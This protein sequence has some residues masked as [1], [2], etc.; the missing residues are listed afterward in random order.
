MRLVL[1]ALLVLLIGIPIGC[2]H[3]ERR[4]ALVIGNAAYPKPVQLTNPA[5]DADDVTA[6]LREVGF[7]VVEG[8][9]LTLDGFSQIVETF[10]QRAKGADVALLFYAGHGMEFEDQN[11]LMPIDTKL[12]SAF[13]ARHSNISLQE[14][15]A[16]IEP[17]V[18][19]TIVFLDA[20]RTNPLADDL[21]HR[22][23]QQMQSQKRDFSETRGLGRIDIKAPQTMVVFAARPNTT[24]EDG[25]GRN[26]PFT[27]AL[28]QHV[29][30]PGVEVEA[31]MKRVSAA[32]FASTDGRQQPERLSRLE[33]E[34]YFVAAPSPA[35][36]VPA[37]SRPTLSIAS[38]TVVPDA[39]TVAAPPKPP[40]AASAPPNAPAAESSLWTM[41]W[42]S[43]AAKPAPT[44]NKPDD[45][46]MTAA[47]EKYRGW[48][49]TYQIGHPSGVS[50]VVISPDGRLVVSSGVSGINVWDA[51]SGRLLRTFA[52]RVAA[53]AVSRDGRRIVSGSWD[54]TVKIWDA[55]SGRLL[56]T[57]ASHANAV[58]AV[59]IS[60]DGHRIV[61]G[62]N[63]TI[64]EWD[65]ESGEILR[66]LPDHAN[67]EDALNGAIRRTRVVRAIA[68]SPDGRR[69][70]SG[71]DDKTIKVWDAESGAVLRTLTGHADWVYAIAVSPD[72]RRIV[73]G[74]ADKTIKIW[75]AESGRLLLTLKGHEGGVYAVTVSS[76]GKRIVSGGNDNAIRV[77][78]AE[79]GRLLQTFTGHGDYVSAVVMSPDGRR[80]V[81][82]S[83]DHSI[84]VWDA[85]NGAVL[86]TL[87]GYAEWVHAVAVSPDGGRVV[88]TG[89]GVKLWD[90]QSGHIL[91]QRVTGIDAIALKRNSPRY[92]VA[93][94]SPDGRRIIW[95]GLN[96][97]S[98]IN[99]WDAENSAVAGAGALKGHTGPLLALAVSTDG[100]RIVSG[101]ADKTIKVWDAE[102]DTELR[103]LTDPAGPVHAVAMSPDGR[104]IV[105]GS[106]DHTIKVWDTESGAVLRTLAG[107]ADP[108]LALAFSPDG[109]RIVSGSADKT[110]KVWDAES[111]A[112]LRTLTG[113]LGSV[114][115]IAVSPDGR[116]IVSSS[117]DGSIRSWDL[118]TGS[119]LRSVVIIDGDIITTAADG[120][121]GG[122]LARF[123]L[124]RGNES[125]WLPDDYK[126]A[127]FRN[128]TIEQIAAAIGR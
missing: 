102:S 31:L 90:A 84:K 103:T 126:A 15:I 71:G 18:G 107:H 117:R 98:I 83:G 67:A 36:A 24:A 97:G 10:Q 122:T 45:A 95:G 124:V 75:D 121:I 14:L 115:A 96:G 13:D 52:D 37:V 39:P 93:A 54:K 8:K 28:L 87:A 78:D 74:G 20:C 100:H 38:P 77:W 7:D 72:G 21:K 116:R 35:A 80:I 65:A 43:S 61:S 89:F 60:P 63:Y 69:I 42:G 3:A 114:D 44:K 58:V 64:M 6:A 125:M 30:T 112:E 119:W 34:F 128:R 16:E 23:K 59:A 46:A 68:L 81:S 9:D 1:I 5:N 113:H 22:I 17:T 12:T 11:W 66:T 47:R 85:E 32:V 49:L 118:E 41:L 70:V 79:S 27:A 101:S 91:H 104:R 105:S 33:K 99:V 62:D 55:E 123:A 92:A 73:S 19:T 4:V 82:G 86:H 29:R 48:T 76:D 51:E 53:V 120:T 26:S 25:R 50:A 111:G 94:M 127:F 110:I 40:A 57:F 88:S 2:A 108:V 109:R 56:R 106:D